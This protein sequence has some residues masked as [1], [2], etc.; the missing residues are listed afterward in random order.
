[1]KTYNIRL[2][3]FVLLFSAISVA[4]A[5]KN[6]EKEKEKGLTGSVLSG[7]NLRGIGPAF[8]SGRIADFAVN[9]ENP[10]EYFVAVASGHIWKTENNGISFSPVFENYGVY[11]IGCITAEPGNFNTLWAGTGENN[12]QRALGY[13]N[14]VY[15]STDRGKSWTNMG[16]KDS[17]QI[18]MIAVH[19][20]NIDV[21]FVA[22]EGSA[23]GPGGDRGLYKTVDGGENW[24]KVLEISSQ[25][26]VNNVVIDPENHS[27][28][29]ATSEQRR[30]HV[31]T[32]IA[33]GPESA[34]YKSTDGGE[35]WN[36]LTNGL[37]AGHIGGMGIAV[38]PVKPNIVYAI[39]EAQ[40]GSGF[41]RST[42]KGE[43]WNKMS[44]HSSSGQYYN[45]IYCDPK[46]PNTV[47]SVETVTHFTS[48]GG[49]T[50]K[51]LGLKNR[52]VDDHALWINPAN[53]KHFIIGGDGGV[54]VSYD[55]GNTFRHMSN[56]PVTQFYRVYTDNAKPFYNIYGGTQDNNSF[57]GPSN[58]ICKDGVSWAEW[59]TTLGGDGFFGAVDPINP[60]IV[61]S[62][63]QYGNLYR[64]DKKSGE[65]LKIKPYPGKDELTYRWNWNAPFMISPHNS[66]RLYLASNKLFR[67]NDRGNSWMTLGGDLTANIDRNQWKVMGKYWSSDAMQKDVSTSLYGTIVSI[68]ESPV[69]EGLLY[70]GCDDGMMRV[71]QN[72]G[73][74]WTVINDFP[75]VP[76][77]TYISDIRTDK[78][79]AAVVYIALDNRKRD[80]FKP[81][82]YKST[83]YGKNWKSIAA[84]L[85]ENGTVHTIEQDFENKN[86][87]FVGTEFGFFFSVNGGKKWIQLKN[88]MPDVAVRDIAIQRNETDVVM[89]TF[90]RGFYILDDYSPLRL[91]SDEFAKNKA[92]QLF[93]VPDARLYYQTGKRYGQGE[94][95]YFAQN[96]PYG[97]TFTYFLKEAPK[98]AKQKRIEKEKEQFK[99]GEK[100]AQLTWKQL[101]DEKK[102][103]VSYLL[104]TVKD[105]KGNAIRKLRVKPSAGLSRH[106]WNLTY[107]N[108]FPTEAGKFDPFKNNDGGMPVLPG[109]YSVTMGM[110]ENEIYKQLQPPV[111]FNV[112]RLN[113]S[114]LPAKDKQALA[115][116]RKELAETVRR[117][118]GAV[119]Y[120]SSA[121][122]K[123]VVLKQTAINTP[124]TDPELMAEIRTAQKKLDEIKFSLHGVSPKASYEEIPPHQLPVYRRLMNVAWGHVQSFSQETQTEKEQLKI[125]QE[126]LPEIIEG[127]KTTAIRIEDIEKKL[128]ALGTV[129]TPGQIINDN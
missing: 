55:A 49:K 54:Y 34:I 99:N 51:A 102:E 65:K 109:K 121:A 106:T 32:K 59:V 95:V 129:W 33:G 90:G 12:H 41:Y 91:M 80:D 31:Q 44:E 74:T 48:D 42:D 60:D 116:Y 23:W 2:F 58:S 11:S 7:M 113:S 63:Y 115:D 21:V 27:I 19:P 46:N 104:F 105:Y 36:K 13:G 84:N 38:S 117:T 45:E 29:Y 6:K 94:T 107:N 101:E 70:A 66:K 28:M 71:S 111:N 57:G 103:E 25:T 88:G 39:I 119:K 16:L 26:G 127:L 24:K 37:P 69:K 82:I 100:I 98:S 30:R 56:L 5:Q 78:F 43:S 86:L 8:A 4:Q 122:E 15:K 72:G 114:S 96:E 79:D 124:K 67:S 10:A 73:K 17:R 108:P 64:Y 14:G 52:H 118:M 18:G 9:P 75:G 87:L 22:A 3:V 68:D 20:E 112:E 76:E 50:W 77:N 35:N 83:N 40:E 92:A 93:E 1:M 81:Y 61:Y 85:P 126:Q 97:A 128:T 47:Y 125:V 62:E 89:A 120:V 53:T 110:V 123:L